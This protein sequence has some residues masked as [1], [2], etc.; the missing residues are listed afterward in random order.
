RRLVWDRALDDEDERSEL[1]PRGALERLEE[2][3]ADVVRQERVVQL[4]ARDAGNRSQDQVLEAGVG[5]G[6]DRERVAV[7]GRAGG[8]AQGVNRLRRRRRPSLA[9]VGC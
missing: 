4:H 5:G 2:A 9:A 7:A 8:D 1:A 6:G 3:V